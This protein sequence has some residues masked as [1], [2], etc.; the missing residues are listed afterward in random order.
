[1]LA[2]MQKET[3]T[4]KYNWELEQSWKA[5]FRYS[6]PGEN[7]PIRRCI[8]TSLGGI[9]A[10]ITFTFPKCFKCF[11]IH[12]MGL[13]RR[14]VKGKEVLKTLM[15]WFKWN[16]KTEGS[17][18]IIYTIRFH[19]CFSGAKMIYPYNHKILGD[20]IYIYIFLVNDF[21]AKCFLIH[22]VVIRKVK[23]IF[24]SC[25]TYFFFW[26]FAV[27]SFCSYAYIQFEDKN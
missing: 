5:F 1:M 7:S 15:H 12:L 21:S 24:A 19:I 27:Y 23:E 2:K 9:Y 22:Y 8:Q 6:D 20:F 16:K 14:E 25:R 18:T 3:T 10:K 26:Q 11:K 4:L 13:Q 17:F